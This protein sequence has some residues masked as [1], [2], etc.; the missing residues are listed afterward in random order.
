MLC[1]ATGQLRS[2]PQAVVSK[3]LE[4]GRDHGAVERLCVLATAAHREDAAQLR[5][6]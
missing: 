3:G 1:R 6:S 2:R 4:D 5:T